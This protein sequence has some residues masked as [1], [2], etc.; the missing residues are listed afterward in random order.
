[1]HPTPT[2]D[3]RPSPADVQTARIDPDIAAGTEGA[4]AARSDAAAASDDAADA[5]GDPPQIDGRILLSD[6]SRPSWL[7]FSEELSGDGKPSAA[8][9]AADILLSLGLLILLSP[10]LLVGLVATGFE[11]LRSKRDRGDWPGR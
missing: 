11:W 2:A 3:P 4:A 9:R 6:P 10:L 8:K 1:M 5:G 7:V